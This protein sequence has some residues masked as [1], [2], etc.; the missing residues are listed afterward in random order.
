MQKFFAFLLTSYK[1]NGWSLLHVDQEKEEQHKLLKLFIS[2]C[3]NTVF[4]VWFGFGTPGQEKILFWLK[5]AAVI[6]INMRFCFHKHTLLFSF[7][8]T[9][10]T[11]NFPGIL[12]EIYHVV[13]AH[14]AG[15]KAWYL[16][17]HI[18]YFHTDKDWNAAD[19]LWKHAAP[20]T[21]LEKVPTSRLK[22][23]VVSRL[24]MLNIVLN[25]G[26]WPSPASQLIFRW[27]QHDMKLIL[28]T[29]IWKY[30]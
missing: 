4:I 3:Y 13:A 21:R 28:Y 24:R 6:A 10:T 2:F 20:L 14:K 25:S 5:T 8:A 11:W 27:C 15:E 16:F 18:L 29:H 23:P 12:S 30:S 1:G 7:A 9:N 17:R 22:H 26:L 19:I